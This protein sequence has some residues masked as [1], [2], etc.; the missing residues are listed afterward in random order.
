[1]GADLVQSWFLLM[2]AETC[3]NAGKVTDGLAA[4]AEALN[5]VENNGERA[6]VAELYRIKGELTL[7]QSSVQSLKPGG[8]EGQKTKISDS[9]SLDPKSQSEAEACFRKA[10]NIAQQQRAK[11]FEL[12]AVMSLVRLRQH[13]AQDFATRSTYHGARTALDE[14][15]KMLSD[16]YQWFTEGFDTRDL[17]E[18]KTLLGEVG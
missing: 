11:S 6:F 5:I 12:R 9:Q 14:S 2:L 10:V 3:K 15:L 13:Q 18:A 7:A 17:Q 8:Q 16:I 1:M 4:V